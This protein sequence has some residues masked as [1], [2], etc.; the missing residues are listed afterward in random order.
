MAK[1]GVTRAIFR[2]TLLHEI[3]HGH[4]DVKPMSTLVKI[5]TRTLAS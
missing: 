2:L 1:C 3:M 4:V 5:E